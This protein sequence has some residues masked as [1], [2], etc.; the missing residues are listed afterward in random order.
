MAKS[1]LCRGGVAPCNQA[2]CC[3]IIARRL[4]PDNPSCLGLEKP[5][6][7]HKC[8]ALDS[9]QVPAAFLLSEQIVDLAMR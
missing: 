2:P 7:R 4:L 3:A 5:P 1:E 9:E 6:S 8:A